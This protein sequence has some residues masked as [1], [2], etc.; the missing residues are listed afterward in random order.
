M[1]KS[2][3]TGIRRLK[4]IETMFNFITL[5]V[6]DVHDNPFILKNIDN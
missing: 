1:N 6:I 2:Y 3:V 5:T 4:I